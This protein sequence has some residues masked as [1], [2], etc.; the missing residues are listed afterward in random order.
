M[1]LKCVSK[2]VRFTAQVSAAS[3]IHRQSFLNYHKQLTG[4]FKIQDVRANQSLRWSNCKRK[5]PPMF[6]QM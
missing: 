2:V 5:D 6:L 3:T 4:H 1:I